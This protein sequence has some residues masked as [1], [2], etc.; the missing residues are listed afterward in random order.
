[1]HIRDLIRL[2]DIHRQTGTA[3]KDR[4]YL[5]IAQPSWASRGVNHRDIHFV[6]DVEVT[7]RAIGLAKL[8]VGRVLR[9]GSPSGSGK[10]I[11]R[12]AIVD[13][14]RIGVI[15]ENRERSVEL[16]AYGYLQRVVPGIANV[17]DKRPTAEVGK[18]ARK[19]CR[20]RTVRQSYCIHLR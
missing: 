4:G 19:L 10:V 14:L 17:I 11:D 13:A 9:V 2:C 18:W 20:S 16:A 12:T 7:H 6:L 5:P 3:N 15:R 8:G 1:R